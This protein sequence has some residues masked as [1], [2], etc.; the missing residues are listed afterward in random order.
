MGEP[1]EIIKLRSMVQ[2]RILTKEL[3]DT[4][5]FDEL[6]KALSTHV[7]STDQ[8]TR[9]MALSVLGRASSVSKPVKTKL[10]PTIVHG[11]SIPIT[12]SIEISDGDDRYY[13][14]KAVSFA[15]KNWIYDYAVE[16][17]A[18]EEIAE[19][20]RT[21]WV[22]MAIKKA[23][24]L[25]SFL[26]D[27]NSALNLVLSKSKLDADAIARR[28]LRISASLESYLATEDMPVGDNFGKQLFKFHITHNSR[29][30]PDERKLRLSAAKEQINS[31]I[32]I[33]R[34]NITA[35]N[36]PELY[37]TVGAILRWWH[38]ATPPQELSALTTRVA[39]IG[40]KTLHM[41]AR[42]GVKR[43]A[44][45][46]SLV[47]ACSKTILGR[48]TKAIADSDPSLDSEIS[49][50]FATGEELRTAHKNEAVSH[51][52][53]KT[54]DENFAHLMIALSSS[55]LN[56]DDIG[57]VSESV[58]AVFP[59]ESQVFK[60]A[61]DQISI[62]KQWVRS[63]ARSRRLE[64]LGKPSEQVKYDP[65]LHDGMND[66]LMNADVKV[67]RPGV[68]KKSEGRP[69]TIIVKMQVRGI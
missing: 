46:K 43:A 25:E 37:K 15:D 18:K 41:Y 16:Q 5:E 27:I 7:T 49:H 61:T 30:G 8:N 13:F 59:E 55:K 34:L 63:L 14:A 20:A 9:M 66:M 38:P 62:I 22:N 57:L 36:D 35:N 31:I 29:S 45:R 48:I 53:S 28:L 4:P 26:A 32:K 17:I 68:V 39:E 64:L 69:D 52:S 44:L 51:Q 3:L 40:S 42:Q 10:S 2:D 1:V 50:W 24:S 54:F 11:L 23:A 67:T 6:L 12:Q 58:G 33:I 60:T 19:K 21:E 65:V 47:D 56:Q